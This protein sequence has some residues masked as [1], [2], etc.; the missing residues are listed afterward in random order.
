[1]G[2]EEKTDLRFRRKTARVSGENQENDILEE[3]RELIKIIVT[4]IKNELK[5]RGEA[6]SLFGVQRWTFDVRSSSFNITLYGMI[7]GYTAF[8]LQVQWITLRI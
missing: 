5:L 4:S 2:R 7:S 8:G 1:M 6:T 3:T